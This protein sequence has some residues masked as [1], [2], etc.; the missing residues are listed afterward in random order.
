MHSYL[1]NFSNHYVHLHADCI[2][3]AGAKRAAIYD[4]TRNELIFF[5]QEYME[6]LEFICSD[7]L[8]AVIQTLETEEEQDM[9]LEFIGFLE[10][11]EC[12][13]FLRNPASFPAI[14]EAWEIPSLIHNAIIDVDYIH[15]DFKK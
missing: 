12:I 7:T 6:V 4:L 9:V 11:H 10:T 13:S 3:V 14:D 5:P 8:A 1:I 2:P 15:H